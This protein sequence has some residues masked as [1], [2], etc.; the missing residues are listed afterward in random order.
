MMDFILRSQADAVI[1]MERWEEEHERRMQRWERKHERSIEQIEMQMKKAF[2]AIEQAAKI[3]RETRR[4]SDDMKQL[5]KMAMRLLA[6]HSNRL[7]ALERG[8]A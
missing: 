4:R 5:M 1:R 6:Q 7:D 3:S 2:T 8:F